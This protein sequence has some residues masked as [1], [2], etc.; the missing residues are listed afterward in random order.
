SLVLTT[1]P[2]PEPTTP[3]LHDALPIWAC[4][5]SRTRRGGRP[6]PR[7]GACPNHRR[8][9]L[10]ETRTAAGPASRAAPPGLTGPPPGE[11]QPS[12]S[13]RSRGLAAQSAWRA[14]GAGRPEPS[15]RPTRRRRSRLPLRATIPEGNTVGQHADVDVGPSHA[16]TPG[17]STPG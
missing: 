16:S 17:T 7:E 9:S 2:R 3:P 5:F 6:R 10:P 1:R 4:P 12:L 14:E 15:S 8:T 13:H 11:A